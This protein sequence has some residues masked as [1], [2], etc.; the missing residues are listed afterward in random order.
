VL[1][2]LVY[3]IMITNGP[4]YF[5]LDRSS[6]LPATRSAVHA[7][8]AC[9]SGLQLLPSA[10]SASYLVTARLPC[11]CLQLLPTVA[12]LYSACRTAAAKQHNDLMVI[13]WFT[14]PRCDWIGQAPV[15][16]HRITGSGWPRYL[17]TF[18]TAQC[19]CLRHARTAQL[20]APAHA[21]LLPYWI[22]G[23]CM[24]AAGL[25][26]P[27]HPIALGFAP[28]CVRAPALRTPLVRFCTFLHVHSTATTRDSMY[29]TATGSAR[30]V[31]MIP[32][33]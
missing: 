27:L 23:C 1:T 30:C 33:S 19:A 18:N 11:H 29:C 32:A 3:Y 16:S 10:F 28:G 24:P 22:I 20:T 13:F 17:F 26:L 4:D 9:W 14:A 7:C 25:L 8:S 12:C 21:R 6:C 15:G 2:P 31:V 5:Y